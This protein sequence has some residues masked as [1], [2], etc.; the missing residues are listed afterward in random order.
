MPRP[1]ELT[2]GTRAYPERYRTTA[3]PA[4]NRERAP[5]ELKTQVQLAFEFAGN[6]PEQAL[7]N[8]RSALE[9]ASQAEYAG[10][11]PVI[12]STCEEQLS[13]ISKYRNVAVSEQLDRLLIVT[14]LNAA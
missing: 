4:P 9:I 6:A 1:A 5:N 12:G 2:P 3:A 11:I 10:S 14:R 13:G 8:S 7:S